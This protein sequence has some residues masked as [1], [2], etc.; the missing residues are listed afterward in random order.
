MTVVGSTD[1]LSLNYRA[2]L[3]VAVVLL[4]KGSCQWW[5]IPVFRIFT[6][7]FW[8]W[9]LG[10]WVH[11]KSCQWH[12]MPKVLYPMASVGALKYWGHSIGVPQL[13]LN[14]HRKRESRRQFESFSI[15]TATISAFRTIQNFLMG[16]PK[17]SCSYLGAGSGVKKMSYL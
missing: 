1:F 5:Q 10:R 15:N 2:P 9:M 14:Y 8:R 17:L 7:V 13:R 11:R 6:L 12:V 16:P 4:F 3:P